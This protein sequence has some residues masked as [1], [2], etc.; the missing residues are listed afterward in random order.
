MHYDTM[1]KEEETGRE[2]SDPCTM[3]MYMYMSEASGSIPGGCRFFTV[4]N[5]PKS[6]HHV[7]M[8]VYTLYM[9]MYMYVHVQ[10]IVGHVHVHVH[11]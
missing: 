11:D 1:E 10:C 3:H 9:Y 7:H 6:F 2:L 5:I 8:H 4:Q